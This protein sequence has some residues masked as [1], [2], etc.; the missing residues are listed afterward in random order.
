MRKSWAS[1]VFWLKAS[2]RTSL[3]QHIPLRTR[4]PIANFWAC[5][6]LCC[7]R[8]LWAEF[9]WAQSCE[10]RVRASKVWDGHWTAWCTDHN[11]ATR[12]KVQSCTSHCWRG[13]MGVGGGSVVWSGTSSWS[14]DWLGHGQGSGLELLHW[15]SCSYTNSR[16][17]RHIL[18]RL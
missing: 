11:F 18:A 17:T 15:L 13:S 14:L 6:G 12:S 2:L 1:Q 7:R 5:R 3:D 16:I 4:V 9:L 8:F 10:T